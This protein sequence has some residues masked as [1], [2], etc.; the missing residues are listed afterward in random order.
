MPLNTGMHRENV[1]MKHGFILLGQ[2]QN[3]NS[4]G[5]MGEK[6]RSK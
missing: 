1:D 3:K 4:D 5:K 6:R 2:D